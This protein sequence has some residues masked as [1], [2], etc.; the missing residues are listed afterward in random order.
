MINKQLENNQQKNMAL[1]FGKELGSKVVMVDT[2]LGRP[3]FDSCYVVAQR[4]P[5]GDRLAII[6]TGTNFSIPRIMATINDLGCSYEQVSYIIL[7]QIQLDHAGGAGLLMQNC[8]NAKL[9]VHP[10]GVRHLIDPSSLIASATSLYGVSWVD[11]EYG[12]LIPIP[13]K[14]IM[15]AREGDLINL[16]G[17][18]LTIL[19]TPGI[20]KHHLCIWDELSQGVFTGDTFG[21]SYPEFDTPQGSFVFPATPIHFDSR[22]LKVSLKKV[23]ALTP[24]CLYFSHFGSF[25][26]VP[27][28]YEAFLKLLEEVENLGKK[29]KFAENRHEFL[30]EGLLNIYTQALRNQGCELTDSKIQ[31]L[32]TLDIE[33]NAQGMGSWLD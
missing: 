12:R 6:D 28:M 13:S 9:V 24:S 10:R 8:P 18:M 11:K 29:L 27:Q 30:K 15:E 33:K 25:Q 16:A 3:Q 20:A 32:L 23:M 22:S 19:E 2:G 5:S 7:T 17:R 31:Q 1:R 14:R 26:H 4:A 21:L